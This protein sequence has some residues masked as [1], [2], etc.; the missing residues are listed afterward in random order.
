MKTTS[1]FVNSAEDRTRFPAYLLRT[2]RDPSAYGVR[3]DQ[4]EIDAEN[5]GIGHE[6][7]FARH[8]ASATDFALLELK[9]ESRK[10]DFGARNRGHPG[11]KGRLLCADSQRLC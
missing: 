11:R 5:F 9:A 4:H 2:D 1:A 10:T 3:E 8:A 6:A 7:A